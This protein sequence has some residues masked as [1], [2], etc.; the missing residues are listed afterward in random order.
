MS[1][2]VSSCSTTPPRAMGEPRPDPEVLNVVD[3]L[4]A[5]IREIGCRSA[6]ASASRLVSRGWPIRC[7]GGS[8]AGERLVPA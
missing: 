2:P 4:R 8:L 5:G 3:G 1:P 7:I 6:G